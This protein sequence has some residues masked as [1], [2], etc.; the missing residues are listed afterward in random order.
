MGTGRCG[1][2]TS[3]CRARG[4]SKD[5][6]RPGRR[7]AGCLQRLTGPVDAIGHQPTKVLTGLFGYQPPGS[8]AVSGVQLLGSGLDLCGDEIHRSAG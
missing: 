4:R 5:R 1:R 3:P 6:V 8:A 7:S 2:L